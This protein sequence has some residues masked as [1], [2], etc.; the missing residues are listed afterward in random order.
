[1]SLEG[2]PQPFRLP[3]L[4]TNMGLKERLIQPPPVCAN[5]IVLQVQ[6]LLGSSKEENAPFSV[7]SCESLYLIANFHDDAG[8]LHCFCLNIYQSYQTKQG[9]TALRAPKESLVLK[10]ILKLRQMPN[11]KQ[12]KL[13]HLLGKGGKTKIF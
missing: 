6:L 13:I 4:F 5:V 7:K 2:S 12:E 1:M 3:F 10:K 9:G 11:E 8:L